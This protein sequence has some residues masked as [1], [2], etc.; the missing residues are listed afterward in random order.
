MTLPAFPVSEGKQKALLER[1]GELGLREEDLEE[2]FIRGS[3]KGGQKVN[4]TSN[5]VKLRHTPTGI[6]VDCHQE[7]ELGLN[8]FF[9]RRRLLDAL[10]RSQ[11]ES[12]LTLAEER[13]RDRV[14]KQKR[15]RRRRTTSQPMD[16]GMDGE[17]HR[18][19]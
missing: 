4:K 9:A 5:G 12:G 16:P 14:R 7:R 10:E 17:E 19:V 13:E 15:R 18:D 3:G 8:R 6:V 2:S 1:Y 11:R